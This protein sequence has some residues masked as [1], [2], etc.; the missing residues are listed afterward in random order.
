MKHSW[1][2]S[3][4]NRQDFAVFGIALIKVRKLFETIQVAILDPIWIDQGHGSF[5]D[6]KGEGLA[7]CTKGVTFQKKNT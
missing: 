1:L 3:D 2:A 5:T 6:T 4:Y 7:L